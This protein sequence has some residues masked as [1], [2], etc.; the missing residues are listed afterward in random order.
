MQMSGVPTAHSAHPLDPHLNKSYH[1]DI[2]MCWEMGLSLVGKGH[3]IRV[4]LVFVLSY[5]VLRH[6][7]CDGFAM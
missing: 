6:T 1:T 4:S 3:I 5:R 7:M 2:H